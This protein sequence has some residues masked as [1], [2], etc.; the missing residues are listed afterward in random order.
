[1]EDQSQNLKISAIYMA[2]GYMKKLL[3]ISSHQ[4]NTNQNHSEVSLHTP[5]NGY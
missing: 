3:S 2:N 4:G 5:Q 1:M